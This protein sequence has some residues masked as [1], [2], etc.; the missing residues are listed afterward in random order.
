MLEKLISFYVFWFARLRFSKFN[1]LLFRLSLSGLGILNYKTS[2]VSGERAFLKKYLQD[3]EGI[4]IDVGANH[5]NYIKEALLVKPTMK[6]YAFEPHPQTFSKLSESLAG[7]DN[8]LLINKGLSSA[9]GILNLYDYPSKEGSQHASLFEDVITEIHGSR[10]AVAHEVELTTL[11]DFVE[12]EK[13][14]KITLLKIDTEGNELE[15]LTGGRNTLSEGKIKAVHFE[16]NEMNVASRAFFKDFWKIL[17][18][19]RFYRLLPN[20]MLEI[21]NYNPLSC[22]IFA[23]QNIVAILQE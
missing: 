3:K 14:E 12:L 20:E 2:T 5:G 6:V 22:E 15:V 19:Y 7:Y 4:L 18:R 8:V 23:Y 11:D 16:F 17:D 21:I 1:K 10:I 9:N 13:I